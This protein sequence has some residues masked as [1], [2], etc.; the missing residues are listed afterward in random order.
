MS[1]TGINQVVGYT[2]Q[3]HPCN[4]IQ[5]VHSDGLF[6]VKWLETQKTIPPK[7]RYE[8]QYCDERPIYSTLRPKGH[9]YDN[10][11]QGNSQ[12]TDTV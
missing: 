8:R 6:L 4:V 5:P 1:V 10:A 2:K 9:G 3:Q 7:Y 12:M 11:L